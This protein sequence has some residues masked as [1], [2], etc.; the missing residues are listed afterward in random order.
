MKRMWNFHL[1]SCYCDY[2]S[3]WCSI[4]YLQGM[5]GCIFNH[6]F[7]FNQSWIT[8]KQFECSMLK[9][10]HLYLVD[11]FI[12]VGMGPCNIRGCYVSFYWKCTNY[13]Y[14]LLLIIY[15]VCVF[16]R[17][18]RI[19]FIWLWNCRI[20]F[21][22]VVVIILSTLDLASSIFKVCMGDFQP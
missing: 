9:K 8:R 6:N 15:M 19:C 22:K 16:L 13:D 12:I 11:K 5:F 1:Q 18:G 21:H 14:A 4:M 17:I 2:L 7:F 10:I 3:T 20:S